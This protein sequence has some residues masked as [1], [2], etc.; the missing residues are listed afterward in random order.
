MT[1]HKLYEYKPN[2]RNISLY[3][4]IPFNGTTNCRLQNDHTVEPIPKR[5]STQT[6]HYNLHE[7]GFIAGQPSELKGLFHLENQYTHQI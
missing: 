7:G 2:N 3:N 5:V 1:R 6:E 4:A